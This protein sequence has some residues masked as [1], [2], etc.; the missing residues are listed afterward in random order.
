MTQII[1]EEPIES[2]EFTTP[3]SQRNSCKKW[4][5]KNREAVLA[6]RR[7]EWREKRKYNTFLSLVKLIGINKRESQNI[8]KLALSTGDLLIDLNPDSCLNNRNIP[9]QIFYDLF[10][11]N[12]DYSVIEVDYKCDGNTLTLQF[13]DSQIFKRTID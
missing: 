1:T 11:I 9:Y 3:L 6:Q 4:Y 7:A 10:I 12:D 5:A 13:H 2:N 8:I